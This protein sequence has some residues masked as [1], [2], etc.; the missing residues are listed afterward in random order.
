MARPPGDGIQ[1]GALPP[2]PAERP[3]IG[4]D[5]LVRPMY[6]WGARRD[7]R[8]ARP[9][10]ATPAAVMGVPPIRV[11]QGLQAVISGVP[12]PAEE[13]ASAAVGQ[14]RGG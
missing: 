2:N 4:F 9:P 3:G 14:D 11:A 1:R 8:D 12:I 7:G 5:A 13:R 6:A 10:G